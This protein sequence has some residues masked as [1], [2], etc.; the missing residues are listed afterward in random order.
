MIVGLSIAIVSLGGYVALREPPTVVMQ[1]AAAAAPAVDD[2]ADEV[3]DTADAAPDPVPAVVSPAPVEAEV[4]EA[5]AEPPEAQAIT[6]RP[7]VRRPGKTPRRP[8]KGPK[9]P[10]SQDRPNRSKG[11]VPIECVLHPESRGCASGD[12]RDPEPDRRSTAGLPKRPSASQIR[13]AMAK[14]KPQ[15]KACGAKHGVGKGKRVRVKLSVVG[16]SGAITKA[17][18][19]EEHEGTAVGRCVAGALRKATLP[20]FSTAQIGIVF[21]VTL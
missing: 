17:R 16:K 21:G 20:R 5:P 9:A 6:P 10:A 15:A 13:S 1:T 8:T 3:A 14:V 11:A 4:A 18:A 2:V 7:R 12:S 19:V